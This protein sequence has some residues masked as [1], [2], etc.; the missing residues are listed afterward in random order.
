ML[1]LDWIIIAICVVLLLLGILS[2]MASPMFRMRKAVSDINEEPTD[3]TEPTPEQETQDADAESPAPRAAC[4]VT[5]LL[6]ALKITDE[7]QKNLPSYLSQAYEGE[8]KLVVVTEKGDSNTDDLL[9]RYADNEHLYTTFIPESSRYMD[10]KKLAV[11]LGVRAAETEWI[12]LADPACTPAS[13]QWLA[14]MAE[15]MTDDHRLVVGYSNFDNEASASWRFQKLYKTCSNFR[16]AM[17]SLAFGTNT[18]NLAFRK[19]DFIEGDGYRGFLEHIGGRFDFIVN[20]YATPGTT[21]V[22]LSP[23]AWMIERTPSDTLW[24]SS[25]IAEYLR[26]QSLD[27]RRSFKAQFFSDALLQHFHLLLCLL[28]IA[29]AATLLALGLQM[30]LP[31]WLSGLYAPLPHIL[32]I[33]FAVISLL[34]AYALRVHYAKPLI[35]HFESDIAS[36]KA[37]F[38]EL[39][40]VWRY[41]ADALRYRKE[42]KYDFTSHKV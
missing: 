12:L 17:K 34:T 31:S 11:T 38:Y 26:M 42:D 20:K 4:P 39:S 2:P 40:M 22:V 10:R 27:R 1:T 29:A 5:I 41:W 7:L 25:R 37:P 15:Q 3:N 8:W 14:Q 24:K 32:L 30:P 36:S 35:A 33:A 16:K 19:S 21:A 18:K 13:D 9:K 6:T 28:V 23:E